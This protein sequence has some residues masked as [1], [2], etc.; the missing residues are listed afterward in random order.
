MINLS[1]RLQIIA[2]RTENPEAMADIGTDHG[3]LPIYML[4]S[5]SLP[6]GDSVGY[7]RP[8]AVKGC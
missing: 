1:E 7:K 8:V 3:F 4:Q 6:Q 2:E 5:G